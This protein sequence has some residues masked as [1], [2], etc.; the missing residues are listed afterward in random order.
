MYIINIIID[1]VIIIII[2]KNDNCI[3]NINADTTL[4]SNIEH[5]TTILS[6]LAIYLILTHLYT[7]QYDRTKSTNIIKS[8]R[9]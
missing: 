9:W 8:F 2:I 5:A 3:S 1:I 7:H 4:T 6:R